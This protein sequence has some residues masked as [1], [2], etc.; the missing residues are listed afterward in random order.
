MHRDIWNSIILYCSKSYDSSFTGSRKKYSSSATVAPEADVE[1]GFRPIIK[2]ETLSSHSLQRPPP[3]LIYDM[4]TPQEAHTGHLVGTPR[5]PLPAHI[6][7]P[8]ENAVSAAAAAHD[9]IPGRQV[10]PKRE[11]LSPSSAYNNVGK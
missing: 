6:I 10:Y 5:E 3:D 1:V 7:T 4:V 11:R 2:H 9:Y 8:R